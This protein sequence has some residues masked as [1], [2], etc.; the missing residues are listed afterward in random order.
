MTSALWAGSPAIPSG[1]EEPVLFA[2]A[3][4]PIKPTASD[5]CRAKARSGAIGDTLFT[6]A[7]R[8]SAANPRAAAATSE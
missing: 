8:S 6:D 1:H 4:A 3:V 5:A 7:R 2:E